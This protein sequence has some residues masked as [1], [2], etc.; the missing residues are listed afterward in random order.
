MKY[1]VLFIYILITL[2]ANSHDSK[3]TLSGITSPPD[4]ELRELEIGLSKAIQNNYRDSQAIY[5]GNMT[6]VYRRLNNISKALECAEE[7]IRIGEEIQDTTIISGNLLNA[8]ILYKTLG[9]F[10]KALQNLIKAAMFFEKRYEKTKNEADEADLGSCYNSIGDVYRILGK[11]TYALRYY[12]LGLTLHQKEK[13]QRSVASS[14]NFIG[15]L[16][17]DMKQYDSAFQY[18]QNSL[19]IKNQLNDPVFESSTILN[20][21]RIF[22]ARSELSQ[23]EKILLSIIHPQDNQYD[24]TTFTIACKE[25]AQVYFLQKRYSEAIKL[26][27]QSIEIATEQHLNSILLDD[28]D[29]QRKISRAVDDYK[30]AAYFDDLYIS[31]NEILLNDRKNKALVESEVKYE[32]Y[33]KEQELILLHNEAETQRLKNAISYGLSALLTSII[34]IVFFAL[35]RARKARNDI[36]TLLVELNHRVKNTLQLL[37]ALLSNQFKF[38]KDES[39]KIVVKEIQNKV[40]SMMNVYRKLYRDKN[41][42]SINLKEYLGDIIEEISFSYGFG[43]SSLRKIVII[44]KINVS[45]NKAIRIG[46]I[47]NEVISNALKYAFN[48]KL[49]PV[50][51][52]ELRSTE[53]NHIELMISDN[54]KG[55]HD[56]SGMA[57]S[58]SLGLGLIRLLCEQLKAEMKSEQADGVSYHF[59]FEK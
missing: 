59:T 43:L 26:I 35:R 32:T 27:N 45:P 38:L 7:A 9:I 30:N 39:T 47:V 18:L 55:F 42:S 51:R 52:I 13:D 20:I 37:D 31:L 25:L 15:Q 22:I 16:F 54:G 41:V 58:N 50:L 36:E 23:A 48:D 11:Y 17:I 44:E 29:L 24:K 5:I 3:R 14:L 10:D 8:G 2:N 6:L 19:K 49:D 53:K 21:S 1:V 46:L 28:Y 56:E 12:N 34:L 40:K 57:E 4:R 33:K